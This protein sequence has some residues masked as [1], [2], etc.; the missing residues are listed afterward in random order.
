VFEPH[1]EYFAGEAADV[2]SY[3]MGIANELESRT[4][5]DQNAGLSLQDEFLKRYPGLCVQCGSQ[6]CICPSVQEATVGRLAKELGLQTVG[7][8]FNPEPGSFATE[9]K[10]IAASALDWA[11]GYQG[12][13]VQL[14][15]DRGDANRALMVLCLKL[16]DIY[17][18]RNPAL[19]DRLYSA[20]LKVGTSE[21]APGTR[22]SKADFGELPH[23]IKT[24]WRELDP[25][26]KQQF[27]G[28][29]TLAAEI[30]TALGKLRVLFVSC[31]PEDRE[32][33]RGDREYRA[34]YEAIHLANRTDEI[35]VHY[36]PASTVDDLRRELLRESYEIIHFS[37]HS[38][39]DSLIFEDTVGGSQE[40][41]LVAIAEL[42]VKEQNLRC[43]VLNSCESSNSAA[44]LAAYTIGMSDSVD[45]AAAIEFARGFYDGLARGRSIEDAANEGKAAARLKQL[46]VPLN[47]VKR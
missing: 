32:H 46:D 6:I 10:L 7:E 11:G 37:G 20:A 12:L 17:R 24:A 43:V 5:Q 33:I 26:T 9:G 3:L 45:D 27:A 36:L 1:P 25:E 40:V 30:G 31:S 4:L 39:R 8:L 28:E 19:A 14:P 18:E 21:A 22:A 38:T 47:I 35:L 44:L 15:F 23:W 16:G 29:E 41:P 2:F 42:L 13:A 34:I